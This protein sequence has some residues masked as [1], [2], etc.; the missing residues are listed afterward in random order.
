ML[1][2]AFGW[3]ARLY[4][5]DKREDRVGREHLPGPQG[6]D[7]SQAEDA[8]KKR[9]GLFGKKNWSKMWRNTKQNGEPQEKR[10]FENTEGPNNHQNLCDDRTTIC[11]LSRNPV[12]TQ[13]LFFV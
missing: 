13:P 7:L 4:A 1:N 2:A 12:K 6:W 3:L 11:Q 9:D 8:K 5:T 10:I